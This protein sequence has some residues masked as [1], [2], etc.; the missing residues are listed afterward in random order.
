[1]PV[2]APS[3]VVEINESVVPASLEQREA[4]FRRRRRAMGAREWVSLAATGA[5][6]VW[7]AV[8]VMLTFVGH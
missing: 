6:S 4:C 1:M 2:A 3:E 7:V 8:V 5:I